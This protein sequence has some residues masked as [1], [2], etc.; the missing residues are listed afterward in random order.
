MKRIA[1]IIA[2]VIIKTLFLVYS[3]P[4]YFILKIAFLTAGGKELRVDTV[5]FNIH[6]LRLLILPSLIAGSLVH[7]LSGIRGIKGGASSFLIF[8]LLLLPE[9]KLL[10]S[11]SDLIATGAPE[12]LRVELHFNLEKL[13]ISLL[14]IFS[15][16][17]GIEIAYRLRNT[18]L[19]EGLLVFSWLLLAWR[20]CFLLE[21]IVVLHWQKEIDNSLYIY[22][23]PNELLSFLITRLF[24][25]FVVGC[26]AGLLAPQWGSLV[27]IISVASWNLGWIGSYGVHYYQ[28]LETWF[29]LFS[30]VSLSVL[31]ALITSLALYLFTH[32]RE[33][34]FIKKIIPLVN[35]NERFFALP[36]QAGNYRVS[37]LESRPFFQSRTS[38]CVRGF[39][40]ISK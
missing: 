18:I 28:P 12:N 1:S 13:L 34:L 9:L 15:I 25:P 5:Y 32:D 10:H 26:L 22:A 38:R 33:K 29:S 6:L 36:A 37:R 24:S 7:S 17:G 20:I 4:Y 3:V 16:S 2:G 23:P 14:L 8:C 11:P 27:C 19:G 40:K 35:G 21:N 30:D 31:F 39:D